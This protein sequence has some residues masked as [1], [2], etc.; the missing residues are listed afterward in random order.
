MVKSV[1]KKVLRSTYRFGSPYVYNREEL[2]HLLNA[3]GLVGEGAEIGV[4]TGDFSRHILEHWK[5]RLLHSI[6]PWREFDE[7]EYD[8]IA[9]VRQAEQ[10]RR[11]ERT[12]EKLAHFGD[13]SHI[14]RSTSAEAATQFADGELDFVYIDAQHHYEAVKEDIALWRP[15][16]KPGGIL[17]GHDYL[18]GHIEDVGLFGVKSA[19]DE[20]ANEVNGRLVVSHE[21]QFPSWFVF[22]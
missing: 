22:V 16:V 7:Q 18:D 2:P 17:A 21:R 3:H 19:V 15:K 10:D 4:R 8:D 5:G 6:D 13:R 12:V 14:V 1:I 20:F 11:Y 9:N